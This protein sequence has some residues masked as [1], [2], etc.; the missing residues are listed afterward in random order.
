MT[1]RC[2]K[3]YNTGTMVNGASTTVIIFH[4]GEI[5]INPQLLH[6]V[7][8][9]NN[10]SVPAHQHLYLALKFAVQYQ[11]EIVASLLHGSAQIRYEV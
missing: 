6:C 5:P 4:S 10:P 1:S 2:Q 11:V 3:L 9:N 7:I 8:Q